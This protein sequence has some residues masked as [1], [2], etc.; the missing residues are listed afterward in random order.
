MQL[1]LNTKH[2]K[3]LEAF[4]DQMTAALDP[5]FGVIRKVVDLNTSQ[6]GG[7]KFSCAD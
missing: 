6:V 1:L 4:L 5:Q 3:T 7:S 2:T